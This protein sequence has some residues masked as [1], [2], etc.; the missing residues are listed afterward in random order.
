MK[1]VCI[2]FASAPRHMIMANIYFD[3]LKQNG[4]EKELQEVEAFLAK[5]DSK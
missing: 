4:M 5:T 3:Y 1:K 2:V